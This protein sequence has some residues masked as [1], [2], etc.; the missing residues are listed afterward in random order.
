MIICLT[1]HFSDCQYGVVLNQGALIVEAVLIMGKG[2][3]GW[4]KTPHLGVRTVATM[5]VIVLLIG[6]IYPPTEEDKMQLSMVPQLHAH[7]GCGRFG[8]V[9]RSRMVQQ[10]G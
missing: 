5:C 10:Q 1:G 8:I 4:R 3:G 2:A 6:C 7:G 9:C